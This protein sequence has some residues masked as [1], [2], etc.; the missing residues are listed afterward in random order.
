MNISQIL[1]ESFV[2]SK[3]NPFIFVPMLV[4]G[5]FSG[6]LSLIF[7]GSAIPMADRYAG[8]QVA[9]N[10]EQAM[11]GFGA[12]L[13]GVFLVSVIS[14]IVGLLAHGMTVAMA[15]L[16]LKEQNAS[17]KAGWSRLVSRL[18]PLIIASIVVGIIVAI[19]S[20]LLLLPGLIVVFLLMFTLVA[21]MVDEQ[22]AFQAIRHSFDVVTKN[23]RATFVLFLVLIALGVI[24]GV[25]S[26][27][28]G[29]IPILGAVLTMIISALYTGYIT[30]FLVR[31][32][33]D[34][35]PNP[36]APPE[37]EV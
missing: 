12:V 7:L 5:A 34:L 15:D 27:A 22:G 23:F 10:P 36:S 28:L 37:A 9:S 20:M 18:T 6:L 35:E 30:I 11:V 33:R 4:A 3:K 32:Y 14:G 29:L 13:S 21:V 8:E 17:L 2:V 1:K 16:E 26:F 25:L 19:A 24:A 31:T